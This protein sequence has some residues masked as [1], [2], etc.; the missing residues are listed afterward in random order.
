MNNNGILGRLDHFAILAFSI[1][2]FIY[3]LTLA[4]TVT[5]FDS[6]EFLTATSSLGVARSG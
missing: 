6:G 4:P 3:L 5:F 1:P 2:L